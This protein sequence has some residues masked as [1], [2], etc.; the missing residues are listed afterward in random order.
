MFSEADLTQLQRGLIQF[1]PVVPGRLEFAEEVRNA[2]PSAHPQVVAVELPVALEKAFQRAVAR[3][4]EISVI[5]YEDAE[6]EQTVYLPVE[7]TDPFVEAIRTARRDWGGNRLCGSRR[8][9]PPS[10]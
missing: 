1:L 4:P 6:Q 9:S 2:R 10:L 5:I 3:L 7:L 8:W